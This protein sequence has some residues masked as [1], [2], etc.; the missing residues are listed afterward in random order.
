MFLRP[1]RADRNRR[2]SDAVTIL[3]IMYAYTWLLQRIVTTA[4][5]FSKK[6]ET[7]NLAAKVGDERNHRK[8]LAMIMP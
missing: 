5:Q 1:A 4:P 7:K 3:F 2:E 6:E 8:A